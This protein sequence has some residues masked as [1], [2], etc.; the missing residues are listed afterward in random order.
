[1]TEN[2]IKKFLE[3]GVFGLARI[4]PKQNYACIHKML[5]LAC[6]AEIP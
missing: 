6:E 3:G 4:K 2:F 1:M 5:S